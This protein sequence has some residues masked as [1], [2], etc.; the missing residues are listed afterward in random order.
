MK[1]CAAHN[2]IAGAIGWMALDKP[3]RKE[4]TSCGCFEYNASG[5]GLVKVAK[6]F[7]GE[8]NIQEAY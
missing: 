2:D 4:F 3:F 8:R 7:M 6:E 5:E 1:Y